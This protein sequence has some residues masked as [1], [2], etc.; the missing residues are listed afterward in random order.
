MA[1]PVWVLSVDLQ[2]KTATFQTGLADAAKAARGSFN[3]IKGGAGEMGGTVN[4][5]M[6]EARHS[7]MLLGEEFGVHLPR[8]LTSYIAS[9]G[10]LGGALEAA[11]PFL[12]IAVGATLLI[13]H[14]VKMHEAGEKLTDDQVKFG[15]AVQNAFNSLDT[16]L[17][18]AQIR[19]DELKN[20]HLGALQL[21]LELID[22]QSMS[23]L[24][25]SFE[26]VAKA[27]DVVM[28][29]LEGHWYTW[30]KGSE[31]A[32]H[33]LDGF[34]TQYNSL[35][36]QGKNEAASG[37]LQG[38]AAQAQEA[39]KWLKQLETA[40]RN[41]PFGAFADPAKFHEAEAE[42][43]KLGITHGETVSKE[44][45][46]QQN[47]VEALN[48][49]I[50]AEQR[51]TELKKIEGSNVKTADNKADARVA[52]ENAKKAA[53]EQDKLQH[54][55]NENFRRS[56]DDQ[57]SITEQGSAARLEVLRA[58]VEDARQTYG[59]ENEITKH[60]AAEEART[61][62]EAGNRTLE[63]VSKQLDE[64]DK[65]KADAAKEAASNDE[66]M[67]ELAI[68]AEKQR[69]ALEDSARRVSAQQRIAEESKIANEEY[70]IKMAALQKEIAGLDKSGKDYE[71]KLRQL[72]D[73]EKQLTQQHENELA[74]IKE[75]AEIE[76]N[77]RILSGWQQFSNQMA[78]GLTQSIMGH[79]T[80]A[81]M[82]TSLGDQVVSGML[83]NAIKSMLAADMDKERQAAKAAR[84]AYNIGM[85]IGGP[86]GVILGPV[87]GAA[88]FAAEMAFAEGGV[89]PGIGRGD[90]VPAMLSPGEG[91]VPGG[92][93]DG[94]SKLARSG[95][96]NSGGHTYN[97]QLRPTYHVQTIDGDGMGAALEKHTDQLQ[98][99]F[100]N[101]LRKMSH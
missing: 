37:L 79:Q 95:G 61:W 23:E 25:R 52:L 39:L 32:K 47:L 44:I 11:F 71:N 57:I 100:E 72:Q 67:G 3:D 27:A 19:S 49:Q 64:E 91:V 14:L 21:Q 8:A 53:E 17:I 35:L 92:V 90:V 66:K 42:L 84:Q 62:L 41:N 2:T 38:T 59:E 1:Q 75:K 76:T 4:Y 82:V 63:A 9:I 58:A 48:A 34:K 12:A 97:L 74:A 73:K 85:S 77:Q 31:G 36:A 60:F 80:W 98:R 33:A 29:D 24:V 65:L 16:K 89:V 56:W 22:K 30:G 13:Q 81:K 40:G 78:N 20:D 86:A 46:A 6:M 83:E 28:K 45:E 5:S 69:M 15:T 10:P 96:L 87:F 101:A 93:M 55:F 18:Q 26:E 94:L 99:H 43:K 54:G 70:A 50:G 7:V 51:I 68:S 88:A